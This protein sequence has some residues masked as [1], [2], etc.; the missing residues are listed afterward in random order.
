MTRPRRAA[1]AAAALVVAA[2]VV[3][4]LLLLAFPQIVTVPTSW[5]K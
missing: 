3:A 2:L 1:F 5:V 4:A